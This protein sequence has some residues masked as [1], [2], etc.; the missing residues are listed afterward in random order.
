MIA[1]MLPAGPHRVGTSN[2]NMLGVGPAFFK[3]IM[4]KKHV[5]LLPELIETASDLGVRL[6]ACQMSMDIM[7]ITREELLDGVEYGGVAAYLGDA[8]D[9]R[10]TLFI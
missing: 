2:M 5:Q 6:V 8:S 10:V 4:R 3:T 7:G 9:S 1:A